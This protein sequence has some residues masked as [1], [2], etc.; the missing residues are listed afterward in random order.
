MEQG[1]SH[2]IHLMVGIQMW[3]RYTFITVAFIIKTDF[4]YTV[5]FM[6]NMK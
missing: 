5:T 4:S 6:A 3:Q 2:R 1:D